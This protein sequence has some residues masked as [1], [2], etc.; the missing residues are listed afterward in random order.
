MDL[1]V[2]DIKRI[3]AGN[4]AFLQFSTMLILVLTMVGSIAHYSR[5]HC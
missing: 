3:K 1:T 4:E 5:Q 2:S